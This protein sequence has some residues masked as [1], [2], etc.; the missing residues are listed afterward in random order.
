MLNSVTGKI[1]LEAKFKLTSHFQALKE[2]VQLLVT[3]G[4]VAGTAT[5]RLEGKYHGNFFVI[6]LLWLLC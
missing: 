3:S 1:Q 4:I 5:A 6:P 2:G